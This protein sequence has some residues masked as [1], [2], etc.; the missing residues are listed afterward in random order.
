MYNLPTGKVIMF[1]KWFKV[2]R[3]VF[4]FFQECLV[5]SCND[6]NVSLYASCWIYFNSKELS[7]DLVE[8]YL[9]QEGFKI[10]EIIFPVQKVYHSD[11]NSEQKK[12]LQYHNEALKTGYSLVFH[13]TPMSPFK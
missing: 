11:Y 5:E 4:V 2:K 7:A 9:A 12:I 6:S 13:P 3:K 8:F 1:F 10:K